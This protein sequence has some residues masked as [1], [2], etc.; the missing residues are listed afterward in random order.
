M[1][2]HRHIYFLNQN[3]PLSQLLKWCPCNPYRQ[4]MEGW[5]LWTLLTLAAI[6]YLHHHQQPTC[7]N[8]YQLMVITLEKGRNR[9]VPP[10]NY[11]IH[12]RCHTGL[13]DTIL[14]LSTEGNN[15]LT[16]ITNLIIN[17]QQ[18][19]GFFSGV[20]WTGP[21]WITYK[22]W[23]SW[24]VLVASKSMRLIIWNCNVFSATVPWLH[25]K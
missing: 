24:M 10:G 12:L 7:S 5:D 4:R 8:D 2:L 20:R 6:R 18:W 19:G 25:K 3:A 11:V 1:F 21:S 15:Y 22:W 13:E 14:E 9:S 16:D 17:T 23:A